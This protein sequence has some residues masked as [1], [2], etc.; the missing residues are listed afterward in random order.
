M[1]CACSACPCTESARRFC[2]V[3]V[4]GGPLR[5]MRELRRVDL[6]LKGGKVFEPAAIEQALGI[7]PRAH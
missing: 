6:T 4:G 3:L 1:A 7:A 2:A 5:D